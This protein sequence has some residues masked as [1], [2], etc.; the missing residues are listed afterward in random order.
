MK[1][2]IVIGL[3]AA[4]LTT[5]N[6]CKGNFQS[7]DYNTVVAEQQNL[8]KIE[9]VCLANQGGLMP[10]SI[11]VTPDGVYTYTLNRYYYGIESQQHVYLIVD[12][13]SN[14]IVDLVTE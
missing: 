7:V 6:G 10:K 12:T 8:D 11:F 13:N 1:K 5:T 14:E 9:V 4:M 2:V 3:A